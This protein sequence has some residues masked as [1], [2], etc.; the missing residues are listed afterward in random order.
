MRRLRRG[1]FHLNPEPILHSALPPKDEHRITHCQRCHTRLN[2][3]NRSGICGACF[4]REYRQVLDSPQTFTVNE[5]GRVMPNQ[6]AR[7]SNQPRLKPHHTS[8]PP[9]KLAA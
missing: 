2:M 5:H 9:L 1:G 8:T 4:N 6:R 7:E 3:Y